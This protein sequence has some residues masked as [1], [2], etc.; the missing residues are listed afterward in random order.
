[1]ILLNTPA[2]NNSVVVKNTSNLDL[3]QHYPVINQDEVYRLDDLRSDDEYWK[4]CLSNGNILFKK[5]FGD[6]R[7]T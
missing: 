1:M 2:N 7:G 5:Y 6:Y 3:M 4:T